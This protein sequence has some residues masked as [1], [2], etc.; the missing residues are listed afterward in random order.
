MNKR[1]LIL[2]DP[3]G[4]PSYGPRLRYLCE[5]LVRKGY[6]IRVV[7]ERFEELRFA[8][9]Y[10]ITTISLYR[11]R[12]DWAIKSLLSLLFDWKNRTFARLVKEAIAGE[13]YDQ[14]YC[15]T[16]ST[17]PLRAA[18]EVAQE[19]QIPLHVDIRDLDEQVPN[20]QYQ[21]HRGWWTKLFRG[22]YKRVNI[23]RRNAV[24]R[25]ADSISTVSPWHV[26]FIRQFNPNVHLVWNGYDPK[27][28]YAED[29]KT[30]EFV[31]GYFG[32]VYEFQHPEIIEAIVKKMPHVRLRFES[33]LA[34][35]KVADE[36]RKCSILLVLTDPTA[37][38]MM[39]TKFYE[40]LGCEKPV[41]CIP[42]DNGLLADVIRKYNVGLASSDEQ[43]IHDFIEEKYREWKAKGYTR[44]AVVNKEDFSREVQA[45]KIQN[46]IA[47]R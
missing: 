42:T 22:W 31:I 14:V 36:I 6:T 23:A 3:P 10:D 39:T 16:F 26:E 35:D 11:N 4:K 47:S 5:Y 34:P 46:I 24:L 12:A 29:I 43:E 40:A 33:S 1:I 44:Q 19:R 15:T 20:A 21:N 41:L 8:H 38:G 30:D 28:F 2:T 25:K 13:E 37:H 9:N 18:L 27:R 17:F 32:K 7:T 45:E